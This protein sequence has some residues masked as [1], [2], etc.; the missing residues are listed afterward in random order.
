QIREKANNPR[1][2]ADTVHNLA[3]TLLKRGK[4]ED[5]LR[6]YGR[7]LDLRRK[8]GDKRGSA[9]ESY[10]IGTIFDNQGRYG[11]AIKSKDEALTTFRDLKQRDMWLGEI[12][13]GYG[14]SL[15]LAGRFEDADKLL[16]AAMTVGRELQ[17]NPAVIVQTQRFQ[18]D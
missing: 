17:N 16:D 3:E 4:Y 9:I 2:L 14:N 11:A 10:S 1:D 12:L 13:S 18:A 5:S 7:A 6:T 8:A 15:A